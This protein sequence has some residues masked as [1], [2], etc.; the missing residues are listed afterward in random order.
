MLNWYRVWTVYQLYLRG[1]VITHSF[2]A[3]KQL[4]QEKLN[5]HKKV[6]KPFLCRRYCIIC[7]IG[8]VFNS[9]W[10]KNY[11][12]CSQTKEII[13]YLLRCTFVAGWIEKTFLT[14][15]KRILEAHLHLGGEICWRLKWILQQPSRN[16]GTELYNVVYNNA[17]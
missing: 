3:A 1:H 13:L 17:W 2:F 15:C 7:C 6:F 10:K 8:T 5:L 9:P 12:R 14:H 11:G 16:E 4:M